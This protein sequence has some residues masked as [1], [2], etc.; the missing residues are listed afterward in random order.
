LIPARTIHQNAYIIDLSEFTD[1]VSELF[2]LFIMDDGIQINYPEHPVVTLRV[3]KDLLTQIPE[4]FLLR[5][6]W[7][8]MHLGKPCPFMLLHQIKI[9]FL[10]ITIDNERPY[11]PRLTALPATHR[12]FPDSSH[13]GLA[14][15]R[16]CL[17]CRRCRWNLTS[18]PQKC[19]NRSDRTDR[20]KHPPSVP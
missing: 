10:S 16:V 19:Q 3:L 20:W 7:S 17:S 9:P 18:L 6:L 13:R 8:D 11:L 12:R 2:E 15:R 5:Y 4:F 1:D 14:P